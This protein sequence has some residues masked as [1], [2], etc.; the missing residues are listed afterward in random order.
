MVQRLHNVPDGARHASN[1][2]GQQQPWILE[3][4]DSENLTQYLL[5]EQRLAYFRRILHHV[6]LRVLEIPNVDNITAAVL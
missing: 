4:Y 3:G 5:D 1:I 6:F 2:I